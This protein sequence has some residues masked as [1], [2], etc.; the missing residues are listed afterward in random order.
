MDNESNLIIH[1]DGTTMHCI[2][3]PFDWLLYEMEELADIAY[4][5]EEDYDIDSGISVKTNATAVTFYFGENGGRLIF[6]KVLNN[7]YFRQVGELNNIINKH[8]TKDE[9]HAVT[10]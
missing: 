10:R 2:Y 3:K 4:N 6:T 5:Y 9:K 8:I 1:D 7:R